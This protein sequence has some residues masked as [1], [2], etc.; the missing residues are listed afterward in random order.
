MKGDRIAV[1]IRVPGDPT[2][3]ITADALLIDPEK[4][5]PGMAAD[6]ASAPRPVTISTPNRNTTA[7]APPACMNARP[8][9]RF[10]NHSLR[11]WSRLL[12]GPHT[13]TTE[14]TG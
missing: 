9:W 11:D 2:S 7:G 12:G 3:V 8:A 13:C 14:M 4:G 5:A 6:P 1:L 10:V